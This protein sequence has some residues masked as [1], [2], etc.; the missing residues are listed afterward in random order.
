M[1][2][3][4]TPNGT[5]SATKTIPTT[6][7]NT[8]GSNSTHPNST[9]PGSL[10][11][12]PLV[13]NAT[14]GVNVTY[15]F[16]IPSQASTLYNNMTIWFQAQGANRM[17]V[18]V[19]K[20]STRAISF[21]A[22]KYGDNYYDCINEGAGPQ[23]YNDTA[24]MAAIYK[25]AT[26]QAQTAS[27]AQI[28][29]MSALEVQSSSNRSSNGLPCTYLEGYPYGNT[30]MSISGCLLQSGIFSNFTV[31]PKVP[32]SN[33]SSSNYSPEYSLELVGSGPV[34]IPSSFFATTIPLQYAPLSP[35]NNMLRL[36]MPYTSIPDSL[37]F[38]ALGFM[39]Y[40]SAA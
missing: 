14:R 37:M 7:M 34:S 19:S 4:F 10:S 27:S 17:L 31:V 15:R 18:L 29:N 35:V 25:N 11:S 13:F 8:F 32:T 23:C 26:I 20:N 24:N 21:T 22:L 40:N 3:K 28:L 5:N 16:L 33:T 2:P 6:I 30:S 36:P 38:T 12:M 9:I 39:A 1:Y